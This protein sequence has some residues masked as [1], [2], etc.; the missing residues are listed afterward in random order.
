[1]SVRTCEG[2]DFY[3]I[4]PK[5]VVQRILLYTQISYLKNKFFKFQ[6]IFK[7][8]QTDLFLSK[9]EMEVK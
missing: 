7:N 6:N 3:I 8:F 5:E 4:F 2:V 1:M 9:N